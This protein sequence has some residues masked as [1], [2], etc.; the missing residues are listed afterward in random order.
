MKKPILCKL[1]LH[2]DKVLAR[3]YDTIAIWCGENVDHD[4]Y[5]H[6][7]IVKCVRCGR[8]REIEISEDFHDKLYNW[9]IPRY[10]RPRELKLGTKSF[11]EV[12]PKILTQL[13]KEEKAKPT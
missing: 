4:L 10:E 13:G 8:Y 3:T 9:K 7:C 11:A 12:L 6:F 1:G 5:H 2:K